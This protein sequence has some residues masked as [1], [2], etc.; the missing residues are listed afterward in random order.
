[1]LVRAVFWR[2]VKIWFEPRTLAESFL[3]SVLGEGRFNALSLMGDQNYKFFGKLNESLF[4]FILFF[5]THPHLNLFCFF[6]FNF[7][8]LF[9]F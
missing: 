8:F 9:L 6:D 1:M 4:R 2:R 7:L 3:A 5:P